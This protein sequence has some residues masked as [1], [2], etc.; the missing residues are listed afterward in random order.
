[1]EERWSVLWSIFSVVLICLSLFLRFFFIYVFLFDWNLVIFK[2]NYLLIFGL[3]FIGF[4]KFF[5]LFL[6]V[7]NIY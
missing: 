6:I 1:M 5:L 3:S 7:Y 4:L 2:F